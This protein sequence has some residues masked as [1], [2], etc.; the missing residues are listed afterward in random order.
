MWRTY[1]TLTDL[2]AVFRSLK[3][4]LGRRPIHHRKPLRAEGQLFITVGAYQAVQVAR[5]RLAAVGERASWTTLRTPTR[6]RTRVITDAIVPS[7]HVDYKH[8]RIKH[9]HKEGRALRTETVINDTYDFR[10]A[11]R[12]CNLD[13]LQ[14]ISLPANRRLLPVQRISHRCQL[15]AEVFDGLPRPAVVHD[16]RVSA[17][18]FG[19]PRVQALLATLLAF[20]LLPVGFANRH[21][22]EHVAPLLCLSLD[23]YGPARATYDLRRLRPRGLIERIPR[24]HRY[25]VTEQGLRIALCHHRVQRRALCPAPSA[26]FDSDPHRRSD[27]SSRTSTYTSG[28]GTNSPHEKLGSNG[29]V[30]VP[31]GI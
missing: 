11:R 14:K 23:A 17:L 30:W 18:R 2:E 3:S 10:V 6:Y 19:D 12:L 26:V 16:R 9:Y 21:L 22:R 4:K 8:S 24:S 28:R 27:D 5:G 15:G 20:R 1:T 7:L 13:D 25:R 29:K 31:Q